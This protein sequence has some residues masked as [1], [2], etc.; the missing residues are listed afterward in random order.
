[1]VFLLTFAGTSVDIFGQPKDLDIL[2]TLTDRW[3]ELEMERA[4]A[5]NEWEESRE[6]YEQQVMTLEDEKRAL[7]SE[8]ETFENLT[9]R[10]SERIQSLT[11]ELDQRRDFLREIESAVPGIERRL[12]DLARRFPPPLVNELSAQLEGMRKTAEGEATTLARRVQRVLTVLTTAERFNNTLT[13]YPEVRQV[14]GRDIQVITIYWGLAAGFAV[15]AELGRGWILSPGEETWN[16]EPADEYAG[17]IAD[18][19]AVYEKRR[20][21]GLQVLPV[22]LE[23]AP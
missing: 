22:K 8:I 6:L 19:I 11:S 10:R 18:L 9:E 3:I 14:D 20:E 23:V 2:R 7:T 12:L 5:L 21:P 15:Q 1:M 16:W 13:L 4:K 17:R